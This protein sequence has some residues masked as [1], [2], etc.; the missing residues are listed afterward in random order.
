MGASNRRTF[1]LKKKK[2]NAGETSWEHPTDAHF[3]E[4]FKRIKGHEE[5]SLK[6]AELAVLTLSG[7][8]CVLCV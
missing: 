7:N 3:K 1:F 4:L 6:A 8:L 2:K 5:A